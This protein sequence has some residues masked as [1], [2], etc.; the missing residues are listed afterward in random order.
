MVYRFM[1]EHRDEYTIREKD[2]SF[3]GRQRRL[4]Q[5]GEEGSVRGAEGRGCGAGGPDSPDT[6]E[7]SLSVWEPPGEGN[8]E[9]GLREAGKP[10]ENGRMMR[11]NGLNARGRRR[12]IRTTNSNHGLE[13][14]DKVL[15][16]EFQA[17]RCGEKWVSDITYLHTLVGRVYLTEGKRPL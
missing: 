15:N 9:A 7:V 8:V 2:V 3:W 13:V 5:M 11:E 12:F 17:G 6:G 16:R 14:Y 1:S 4:L 10:E